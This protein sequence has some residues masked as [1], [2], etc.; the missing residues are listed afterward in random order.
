MWE[1]G[2][3]LGALHGAAPPPLSGVEGGDGVDYGLLFVL[4]QLRVD[5]QSQDLGGSLFGGWEIAAAVAVG[6]QAGLFVQ[7]DGVVDLG[8]DA[9]FGEV[10]AQGVA[11]RRANDV[12]VE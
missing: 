12:L 3:G 6:C 11:A 10:L 5:G 9:A 7:R 4:A 1:S 2:A 8:A